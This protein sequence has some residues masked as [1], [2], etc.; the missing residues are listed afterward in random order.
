MELLFEVLMSVML[1]AAMIVLVVQLIKM[2]AEK[3]KNYRLL[4]GTF[5][6]GFVFGIAAKCL[7]CKNNFVAILFAVGF[8]L[9]YTAFVFTFPEKRRQHEG[10]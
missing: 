10:C 9:A 4:S 5:A 7:F 6:A 3:R 2:P 8:I 1:D